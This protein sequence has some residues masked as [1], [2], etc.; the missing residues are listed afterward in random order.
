MH[1]VKKKSVKTCHGS[2][3]YAGLQSELPK[4]IF[5]PLNKLFSIHT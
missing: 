5:Q 2:S 4:V 1:M 3:R